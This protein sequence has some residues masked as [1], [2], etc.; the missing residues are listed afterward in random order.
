LSGHNVAAIRKFRP[1]GKGGKFFERFLGEPK[2]AWRFGNA[3]N[4]AIFPQLTSSR[5][6]DLHGA[7]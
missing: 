2:N 3:R 7:A 4:L 1:P 6:R 5:R